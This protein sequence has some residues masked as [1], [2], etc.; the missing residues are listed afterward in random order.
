MN[1]SYLKTANIGK[2]RQTHY[3]SI[4]MSYHSSVLQVLQIKQVCLLH[5]LWILPPRLSGA[6]WT[7]CSLVGMG[8]SYWEWHGDLLLGQT[9]WIELLT[10]TPGEVCRGGAPDTTRTLVTW[11]ASLMP[12]CKAKSHSLWPSW[13]LTYLSPHYQALKVL[14]TKKMKQTSSSPSYQPQGSWAPGWLVPPLQTQ[15]SQAPGQPR[16]SD[17]PTTE[18]GSVTSPRA[19]SNQAVT[20]PKWEIWMEDAA[21]GQWDWDPPVARDASTIACFL[22]GPRQWFVFFYI[23]LESRSLIVMSIQQIKYYDLTQPAGGPGD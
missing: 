13:S 19:L 6:L 20:S 22:W 7:W 15:R 9:I 2:H 5:M 3:I 10:A 16:V 12:L 11:L 4:Q 14:C 23:F 8:Y 18:E 21:V 17:V 1:Q